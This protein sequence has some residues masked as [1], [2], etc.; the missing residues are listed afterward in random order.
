MKQSIETAQNLNVPL[1]LEEYKTEYLTEGPNFIFEQTKPCK[2]F[3]NFLDLMTQMQ[4]LQKAYDFSLAENWG[5]LKHEIYILN[6]FDNVP[7]CHVINSKDCWETIKYK[8]CCE[9]ESTYRVFKDADTMV[10]FMPEIPWER[11][12]IADEYK[13]KQLKS[14]SGKMIRKTFALQIYHVYSRTKKP[15]IVVYLNEDH[16]QDVLFYLQNYYFYH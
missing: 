8:L 10:K 9:F 2:L 16:I 3:T 11:I 4:I 12:S 13:L 15:N 7:V 1:N 6:E 5:K 14:W